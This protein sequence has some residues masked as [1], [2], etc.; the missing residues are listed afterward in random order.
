MPITVTGMVGAPAVNKAG[1]D[2]LS[3]FVNR[4]VIGS[5]LL[6]RAVEEA[7]QGMLMQGRH[8]IAI[9]NITFTA[10]GSG[11]QYSPDQGRGEISERAGGFYRRAAGGAERT[12]R[13]RAGDQN[14]R[15]AKT[16]YRTIVRHGR[17]RYGRCRPERTVPR[18]LP[19]SE[20]RKARG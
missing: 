18:L 15:I 19:S 5:R 3:F 7:Y 8:P 2:A 16:V 14:R 12:G 4:R 1:R 11:R 6:T 17:S 20:L 10:V 13:H 9:I